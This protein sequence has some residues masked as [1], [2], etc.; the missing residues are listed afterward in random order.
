MHGNIQY[1]GIQCYITAPGTL[2]TPIYAV[3]FTNHRNL[4][5]LSPMEHTQAIRFQKGEEKVRVVSQNPEKRVRHAK[6]K[7][8]IFGPR[9]GRPGPPACRDTRISCPPHWIWR[10]RPRTRKK[11]QTLPRSN[12]IYYCNTVPKALSPQNRGIPDGVPQCMMWLW[13]L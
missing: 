6:K 4:S 10:R 11:A 13:G 3:F 12:T 7:F 2:G 8:R 9:Q 1:Y 5:F